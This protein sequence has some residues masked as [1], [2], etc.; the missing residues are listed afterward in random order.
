MATG[1]TMTTAMIHVADNEQ[2]IRALRKDL[3]HRE[4]YISLEIGW[5]VTVFLDEETSGRKLLA[6]LQNYY[7]ALDAAVE[8]PPPHPTYTSQKQDQ[9]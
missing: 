2:R 8:L 3:A 4:P 1:N 6:V 7:D 9:I 5:D